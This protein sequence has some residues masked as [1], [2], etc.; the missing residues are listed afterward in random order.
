MKKSK[1][2][3]LLRLAVTTLVIFASAG[4]AVTAHAG[5]IATATETGGDVVF[6]GSGSLNLTAATLDS[7][8][9]SQ[10]GA[11]IPNSIFQIGDFFG[12]ETQFY[13]N[14]T[15][16]SGP[17]TIGPGTTFTR[18]SAGTGDL[19]GVTFGGSPNLSV[20][21][22]YTFGDELSG[23]MTIVG[24]T[25]STLG[26]SP[27]VYEWTWGSGAT[28]DSFT[29]HVGAVPIDTDLDGIA[30]NDDNCSGTQ[31]AA[32]TDTDFDGIGNACDA[33]LNNDCSVNFGDLA[34]LKA[35]FFPNPYSE[36]ADFDGDGFVNFGDLALMKSTFFNGD[37]PGPG[38]SGLPNDCEGR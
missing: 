6:E 15:N 4:T 13:L 5:Y 31:N 10:V 20:P 21:N 25:F 38:P 34:E 32:Q 11:L 37:N 9:S 23:S 35:S 27:G 19:T 12:A 26:L 33:D 29:L 24:H 3:A 18:S 22:G 17:S 16:F 8:T 2:C 1:Q 36:D 14:P 28:A 30:D 7:T